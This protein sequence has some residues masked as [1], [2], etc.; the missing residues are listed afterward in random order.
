VEGEN[1]PLADELLGSASIVDLTKCLRTVAPDQK[2]SAVKACAK[3]FDGL[4]LS[5]RN[6]L[7]RSALLDE[8]P[9]TYA[10]SAKIVRRALKD[11]SFEGWML[12]PV[13]EA[14]AFKALSSARESDFDDGLKLL[15]QLTSRF[16]SEF[17]IRIFLNAD[18]ERTIAAAIV[19]TTNEDERVRRLA[20]EGTRPRL[21]WAKSVPALRTHPQATLAILDLLYTDW[22]ETVRRSVANHLND[23]SRFDSDLAVRTAKRW[24][25]HPKET[26]PQLV[27]HAMRTLIKQAHPGA[28]ALMGF[29]SSE[30]ISIERPT[31]NN[32]VVPLG[33]ELVFESV[34]VNEGAQE[35]R[36]VIDYVIHYRKANG[37]SAP[38]VFK[39]SIKMLAPGERLVV[40][41]HHSFRPISTRKHYVGPHALEIQVN[42]ARSEG[43][44]FDVVGSTEHFPTATPK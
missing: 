31:L 14:L 15:A 25:D 42:G 26:T 40:S 36:L 39:L 30:T 16:T 6:A 2:W 23:I 43:V 22:S 32:G 27:R 20:S 8:L 9:A 19:W 34:V 10:S 1:V 7:V 13:G 41:K 28:L 18:L 17:A 29:S 5:E 37:Q 33:G 38:R 21:P 4:S 11:P 24:L 44:V 3:V 35:A 12:W